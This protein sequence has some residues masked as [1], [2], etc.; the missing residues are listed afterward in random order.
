MSIDEQQFEAFEL[1]HMVSIMLDYHQPNRFFAAPIGNKPK[2]ILDIGTG[3][4]SWAIDVADQ[5]PEAT[6][7][8]VDL[9]PPPVTWVPPNCVLEVDDVQRPW[10]WKEPFD[11]IHIRQLLGSFT[12]EGWRDLYQQCY[13]NLAPDGWIEQMEFDVRVRSDD[14]S[15][16]P[17]S[18]L[19]GW[20]DNFIA[21]AARAGRSLTTQET[22]RAS[23]EA[24]GF[25]DVHER[26]YKVPMGPW[27]KDKVLKE[28]G[29]LNLEHWKSGLEGYAMW[30]LTKFGAPTPWTKEEVEIYLVNVRKEL[31]NAH[32]HGYGY[33]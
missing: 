4:G 33:A 8:G 26:L 28:V 6:V 19:A 30:L 21:C 20:G 17:N 12:P 14:G 3:R 11:L 10:T 13:E 16:P 1:G 24:A 22:M 15:L 7:R 9:F 31:Q 2:H 25:V 27:P 32:I 29:L 5:Y 18:V 23:I